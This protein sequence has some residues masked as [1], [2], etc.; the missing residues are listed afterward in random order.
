MKK[1][2]LMILTLVGMAL[3][4]ISPVAAQ[5]SRDQSAPIDITGEKFE[6]FDERDYAIWTGDVQV[7][8]GEAIL[9]APK[10]TLYGINDGDLDRIHAVGGIRYTNGTEA[11]SGEEA[12]YDAAKSIIVVTGSVVVVQGKQVLSGDELVYHTQT[13]ELKFSS[14]QKKRVRGIFFTKKDDTAS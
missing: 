5:L 8:Q 2:A 14:T 12:V 6:I 11:I 4:S 1:T 10:L 7:V 9:T 13:G 3:V